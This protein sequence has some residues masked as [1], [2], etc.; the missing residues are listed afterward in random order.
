MFSIKWNNG[1][2][3]YSTT[4]YEPFTRLDYC[5]AGMYAISHT[6]S[7][8]N[9]LKHTIE[10]EEYGLVSYDTPICIINFMT[11]KDTN[12]SYIHITVNRNS[13]RCSNSTIHQFVRF[14]RKTIGNLITYQTIKEFDIKH[15]ICKDI[16]VNDVVHYHLFWSD[17]VSMRY[18][19]E[20]NAHAIYCTN[21]E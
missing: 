6:D 21:C 1:I 7:E 18:K 5:N 15:P 17:S 2:R 20:Q 13:Y 14:L 19:M 11:D 4:Y 16:A 8:H 9:A 12:K 3:N 10:Y